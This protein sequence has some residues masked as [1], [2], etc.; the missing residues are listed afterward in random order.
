LSLYRQLRS[1]D[2]VNPR[3]PQ[4]IRQLSERRNEL[5]EI[6]LAEQLLSAGVAED[7]LP[8]GEGKGQ[9][10]I[11]L[12]NLSA[13]TLEQVEVLARFSGYTASS[14]QASPGTIRPG[15]RVLLSIAFSEGGGGL[16]RED[17]SIP[18]NLL[19]RY[20]HDHG[21]GAQQF[22]LPLIFPA[23]SLPLPEHE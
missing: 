11:A 3:Y 16:N 2:P 10:V 8:R 1:L 7:G 6:R 15:G 5:R 17:L 14:W 13:G 21:E 23:G 18:C 22:R 12:T 9:M 4:E 20:Q 19:V